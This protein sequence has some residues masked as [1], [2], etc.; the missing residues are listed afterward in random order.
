METTGRRPGDRG[1][2]MLRFFCACF[3]KLFSRYRAGPYRLVSQYHD[4]NY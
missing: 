1:R 3:A 2:P 4:K